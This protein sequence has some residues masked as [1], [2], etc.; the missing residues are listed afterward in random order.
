MIDF[1]TKYATRISVGAPGDC[2]LWLGAKASAGYGHGHR[3][4][5]HFYAHRAAYESQHGEGSAAGWVIRH[6]CDNPPCCNPG[7][8]LIGTHADNMAD[9]VERGRRNAVFGERVNTAR[10][11]ECDVLEA[12]RLAAAGSPV[13]DVA[14]MFS[15][16]YGAMRALIKGQTWRHLPGAVPNPTKA[17]GRYAPP[18]IRGKLISIDDVRS[19]R[20]ALSEGQSGRALAKTYGIHPATI[21][22]IKTRRIWADVA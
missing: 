19:I 17:I 5:V 3:N 10:M 4:N 14:R 15:L 11:S 6:T 7:H 8:L 16:E 1:F 13:V 20:S 18:A 2:W 12:R 21:S 22:A 9:M